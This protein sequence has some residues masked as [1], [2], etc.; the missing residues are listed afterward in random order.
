MSFALLY[1][2]YTSARESAQTIYDRLLLGVALSISEHAAITEGDLLSEEILNVISQTTKEKIY[3][4]V[5]GPDNAF[6]T[7]YDGLP[8]IPK[9]KK[10]EGGVPIF[11]DAVY[12]NQPVRM[13]AL[14]T[15]VDY[16][17]LQGWMVVQV[18]QTKGERQAMVWQSVTRSALHLV[19]VL[20]IAATFIWI[21]VSRGLL[22]LK[23]L[24][25]E[26]RQRSS[27]DLRPVHQPVPDE[28]EHVVKA[29]NNLLDRLE[30][31]IENTKA[32]VETA[33]HQLRTPLAALR[34]R[35][36]LATRDAKTEWG[37]NTLETIHQETV[38]AS[39]LADQLL[40]LARI[41]PE[42]MGG[43]FEKE[44]DLKKLYADVSREWVTRALASDMDIEFESEAEEVV[45]EG[46]K[47]LL[48][49]ILNNLI[50]NAICY[51]PK[52]THITIRVGRT[53]SKRAFLEVED[54]GPGIPEE[55]RGEVFKRF[56]RLNPGSGHGCGLG[57]PIVKEIVRV[58]HGEIELA[59]PQSGMGLVV[60]VELPESQLGRVA[61]LSQT[62]QKRAS[63]RTSAAD[64]E[65]RSLAS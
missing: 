54:N 57:L 31:Y 8:P 9:N 38:R 50:D 19:L 36:E 45:V 5:T 41:E 15:F 13:V 51:C 2:A 39:R 30:L 65:T 33:S 44:I 10:L 26:I 18:L 4:N 47:V 3:Y 11:Y 32:F 48:C 56:A 62:A 55:R 40:S 1:E 29:L 42:A 63:V 12:E 27:N 6:I 22:P 34:T 49:E 46:N 43:N 14:S 52:G 37:R 7:G 59:A 35:I 53:A 61:A 20:I 16:L 25:E 17:E 58:H 21:G 23:S 28:I 60:R 64:K 24:E